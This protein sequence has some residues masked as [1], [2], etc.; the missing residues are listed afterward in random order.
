LALAA[1]VLLASLSEDRLG[2]AAP[3]LL[4]VGLA[5]LTVGSAILFWR[6]RFG[7]G[8]AAVV[9]VVAVIQ[10]SLMPWYG[11]HGAP[12]ETGWESHRHTLW[13]LGHVH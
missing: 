5:A 8:T 9:I 2:A 4:A 1:G 3:P 11:R 13:Q 6:R 12:T 7:Y 10:L